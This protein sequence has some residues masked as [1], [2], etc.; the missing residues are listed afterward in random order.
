MLFFG[1]KNK[2]AEPPLSKKA[3]ALP[4]TKKVQFCYLKQDEL[5]AMLETDLNSVLALEPVNYYASKDKFYLCVFYYNEGY[6]EILMNFELHENDRKV[7]GG[8]YYAI[9]K[10]LYRRI[11]LKFG[12]RANFN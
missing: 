9:D 5:K 2:T 4:Y 8:E 6:E 7:W 10:E 11:L 3:K 1:K 12:Q